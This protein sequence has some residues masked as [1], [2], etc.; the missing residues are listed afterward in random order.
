MTERATIAVTMS[1]GLTPLPLHG[2]ISTSLQR[3]SSNRCTIGMIGSDG[4]RGQMLIE[5]RQK[6]SGN[7]KALAHRERTPHPP[8]PTP[9]R[10]IFRI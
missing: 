1:G 8:P 10:L 9:E 7:G 3:I 2:K 6:L 5:R 4:K